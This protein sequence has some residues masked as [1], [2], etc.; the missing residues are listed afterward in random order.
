[1]LDG[2]IDPSILTPAKNRM[3][4]L[5]RAIWNEYTKKGIEGLSSA[6]HIGASYF[7]KL[8]TYKDDADK[9]FASL[10]KYH[11]K[12]LLQEYLRGMDD[13]DKKLEIL[14]N[15]YNLRSSSEENLN[16]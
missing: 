10:W 4:S 12:P 13:V 5:N 3:D 7:L 16:T 8:N 1:M 11:I 14:E 2:N 15:A 9:G 6:Y